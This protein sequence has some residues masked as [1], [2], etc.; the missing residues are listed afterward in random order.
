MLAVTIVDTPLDVFDL[1][2]HV[3]SLREAITLTNF[4][5]GADEIRFDPS[6]NNQTLFLNGTQLP[7]IFGPLTITGPG[8][9]QLTISG[10]NQSRVFFVA[11]DGLAFISDLTV[12]GGQPTWES[13][14]FG[15]IPAAGGG[16][17][18]AGIL[19][20][21]NVHITANIASDGGGIFNTGAL[22][23]TN[24]FVEGNSLQALPVLGGGMGGGITNTGEMTLRN[25]TVTGNAARNG[26]GGISTSGATSIFD[27]TVSGNTLSSGFGI[28]IDV[29][30]GGT[31]SVERSTISSHFSPSISMGLGGGIATAGIV[32]V[33]NSTI[34]GNNGIGLVI[35]ETGSLT[36][37]NVTVGNNAVGIFNQGTTTLHNTLVADN[38]LSDFLPSLFNLPSGGSHNLIGGLGSSGG[39]VHGVNGNIVGVDP[40]LA[41][42]ADNGGSTLTHALLAGSPA[43]DAG[44][45]S[46]AVDADGVRLAFDQ[47][48]PG[49]PRIQDGTVDV[50]AIEAF[51]RP[52]AVD[53]TASTDEDHAVVIRVLQNDSGNELRITHITRPENGFLL[54]RL[55]NTFTYVPDEHFNGHDAFAYTIEDDLGRTDSATVSILVRN[56]NDATQITAPAIQHVDE[57]TPFVFSSASGNAISISDVDI[58]GGLLEVTLREV[59]GT[60]SL[61]STIGIQGTGQGDTNRFE[62]TLSAVNN[63][64]EGLTFLPIENY[65]GLAAIELTVVDLARP[66]VDP[67]GRDT[68]TISIQVTPVN[69]APQAQDDSF[70]MAEDASLI[71]NVL[72]DNGQAEDF[73]V[74]GDPLTVALVVGSGPQHGSLSL[75]ADGSFTYQ[76]HA[77][78]NGEDG[79]SYNV[80]DPDGETDSATVSLSVTPVNDPPT[81]LADSFITAEDTS[82][83]ADVLA[84][85]GQGADFDMDGDSLSVAL[86]VGSGPQHGSLSLNADGSFTYQPDLNF[87]GEDGFSYTIHD[88]DGETDTATVSLSVTPV[89]DPPQALDD[90]FITAE[91]AS[92]IGNVLADNGQAEDFDVDGDPLSVALVVGSGPQHGSLSLNANG[93]F[94]YQPHA[95]FNGEDGF[96]YNVQDP[97][98]ETDSATVSLSVTPVNDPPVVTVP[99]AQTTPE[100]VPIVISGVSVSDPDVD[101]GT[102]LLQVILSV[103]SGTV[104]VAIDAPGGLSIGQIVGNGTPSA[105]LTGPV[106]TVN[107]TLA[108]GVTYLGDLDFNGADAL[109]VAADDLGN[110]GVPGPAPLPQAVPI[111]VLS[112][113][114]QVANIAEMVQMQ[115]ALGALNKGQANSLL[116]RL[117]FNGNL[118]ASQNRVDTF[119]DHVE[120]LVNGGVLTHEAGGQ[121]IQLAEQLII[122]FATR[123]D[124]E[125]K[126]AD[127]AIADFGNLTD[128]LISDPLAEMLVEAE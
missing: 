59:N 85:N 27:S 121:L 58:G 46:L 10:N 21:R 76:P 17:F 74:D 89:N 117:N 51:E 37:R 66:T 102:G 15:V 86:V 35:L 34:S 108:A 49:F 4:S 1:G 9:D 38:L 70:S 95:N 90:S 69:D 79:F 82:L 6:L 93:S 73:D 22:T 104:T 92:L 96:S 88:P 52:V 122:S 128:E 106:D 109:H 67:L 72:A 7:T 75:N 83:T 91:D 33:S 78:F 120:G 3:T 30:E 48:G 125:I 115:L 105:T 29:V 55:D 123:A 18:N 24:I 8:A 84:D 63:A 126:P 25:S 71:G 110:T 41:T 99:G 57:D 16:I 62:G 47:R 100:D 5:F 77:N 124:S 97:D 118:T 68:A 114:E 60:I 94:T 112:A 45:N 50:G 28:G 101:E 80:Q 56:V 81:A 36:A 64:L 14:F 127:R 113:V 54:L 42:L 44:S 20:I 12:T 19:G 103:M 111:D 53:D 61:G 40:K 87:N 23:A 116:T 13:P 31:L 119:I 2:D 107:A 65:N 39:F 11:A 98:G 26:G 43:I 32:S